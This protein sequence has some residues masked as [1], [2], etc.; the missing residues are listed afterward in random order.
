M[1]R[2]LTFELPTDV[3]AIERF[4]DNLLDHGRGAG[5]NAGRLRLN[6]RV[7]LTEALSNAML[8]GNRADP[9]RSVHVE[10]RFSNE[11]I[12]VRVTD[13]GAG[14][15][16]TGVPD[17]TTP[18]NRLRTRGRGIFLIRQLMDGVEYNERGNSVEMR[19]VNG[20]AGPIKRV[21]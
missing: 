10:A 1:N 5:F 14:F 19:L 2:D 11:E 17:P 18:A 13:E 15:D 21:S 16:P 8:Y 3:R 12:V 6:L 9:Q 20:P 7:G 4:V